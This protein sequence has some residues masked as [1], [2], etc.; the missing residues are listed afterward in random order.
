MKRG[1]TLLRVMTRSRRVAMTLVIAMTAT[2]GVSTLAFAEQSGQSSTSTQQQ[3]AGSQGVEANAQLLAA[4]A[5]PMTT[6]EEFA[7]KEKFA[8]A[9]PSATAPEG[10]AARQAVWATA[11]GVIGMSAHGGVVTAALARTAS[12]GAVEAAKKTAPAAGVRGAVAAS[13]TGALGVVAGPVAVVQRA[14]AV[15]RSAWTKA[16][17]DTAQVQVADLYKAHA[18]ES[19]GMSFYYD[20]AEDAVVVHGDLSPS[21]TAQMQHIRGVR[22]HSDPSGRGARDDCQRYADCGPNAWHFGSSSITNNYTGCTSGFNMSAAAGMGSTYTVTAGHCGNYGEQFYSGDQFFGY[23]LDKPS[24]PNFD[25]EQI[26][27]QNYGKQI[28]QQTYNT[29]NQISGWTPGTGFPAQSGVCVSGQTSYWEECFAT[30]SSTDATLCVQAGCTPGL[31]QYEQSNGSRMTQPGDS[32]A[33]IYSLDGSGNAQIHGIHIG[34]YE[35]STW[36]WHYAEGFNTINNYYGGGLRT[37]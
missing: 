25:F 13:T 14:V 15:R 1:S 2:V 5:K 22:V 36:T 24:Y 19:K 23:V 33:P 35:D 27:G 3:A 26:G 12:A 29:R 10:S 6:A 20:A 4:S 8:A 11:N 18:A 21:L 31:L 9:K 28:W 7:L 17:I 16:E 30:V 37:W 34:T 32:G